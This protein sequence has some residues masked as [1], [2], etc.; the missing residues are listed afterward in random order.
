MRRRVAIL[1]L[2][3]LTLAGQYAA[4][5][6]N[7]GGEGNDPR[8]RGVL[9]GFPTQR[10]DVKLTGSGHLE[11]IT[12]G[13]RRQAET[14]ACWHAPRRKLSSARTPCTAM[15]RARPGFTRPV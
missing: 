7:G 13:P 3:I 1:F 11:Y 15:P 14:A 6:Q 12:I 5:Q 2:A 9:G 10:A 4:A 8:A